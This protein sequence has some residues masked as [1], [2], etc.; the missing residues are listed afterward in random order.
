MFPYTRWHQSSGTVTSKFH[1]SNIIRAFSAVFGA[2]L[3]HPAQLFHKRSAHPST[4]TRD[5][6][7]SSNPTSLDLLLVPQFFRPAP[8]D[9]RPSLPPPLPLSPPRPL[10]R[11]P[12]GRRPLPLLPLRSRGVGVTLAD[13]RQRNVPPAVIPGE[14]AAQVA[15]VDQTRFFRQFQVL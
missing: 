13:R 15:V 7:S 14:V 3:A 1:Q 9:P 6:N 8:G 10:R 2:S 12:R 4:D 5:P 11:T